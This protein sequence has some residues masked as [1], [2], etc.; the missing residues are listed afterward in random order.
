M[1]K[2]LTTTGKKLNPRHK[3]FID[4]FLDCLNAT[5]AYMRVY[6][7]K[8]RA[9]AR[10]YGSRLRTKEDISNIISERIDEAFEESRGAEKLKTLRVLGKIRDSQLTDYSSWTGDGKM[11]V[12]SSKSIDPTAIKEIEFNE[13]S[14]R[15]G[16]KTIKAKR[17]IIVKLHDKISAAREMAKYLGVAEKHDHRVAGFIFHISEAESGW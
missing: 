10:K 5:E 1:K 11:K 7:C 15:I 14:F 8:S 4:E 6:K 9:Q 12:K 16:K 2:E 3:R 17:Q 13:I